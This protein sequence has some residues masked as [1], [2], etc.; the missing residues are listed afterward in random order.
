MGDSE[1][2]TVLYLAIEISRLLHS[3]QNAPRMLSLSV[4]PCVHLIAAYVRL[5]LTFH[6]QVC[7]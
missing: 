2:H 3:K 6:D 5:I 4:D 7:V 1:T